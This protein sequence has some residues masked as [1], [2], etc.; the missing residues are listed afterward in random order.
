LDGSVAAELTDFH[1]E[2]RPFDRGDF[3]FMAKSASRRLQSADITRTKMIPFARSPNFRAIF[4]RSRTGRQIY[5]AAA[6]LP[7]LSS[8]AGF[9]KIEWTRKSAA[10]QRQNR[11]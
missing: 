2:Q 5:G 3:K 7:D 6:T 8:D 1:Q 10:N 11:L 9:L 4:S